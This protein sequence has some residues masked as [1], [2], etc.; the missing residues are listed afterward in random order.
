MI[1][2]Q[3]ER[4][5][6]TELVGFPRPNMCCWEPSHLY[7]TLMLLAAGPW[8]RRGSGSRATLG[9]KTQ[10][11]WRSRFSRNEI[12]HSSTAF[13]CLCSHAL[14][15]E[16]KRMWS[17]W[18]AKAFGK[19]LIC[20]G[21]GGAASR[22]GIEEF[23]NNTS[24]EWSL[25]WLHLFSKLGSELSFKSGPVCVHTALSHTNQEESMWQV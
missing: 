7:V 10:R 22:E 2:Y 6:I 11:R 19:G 18:K 24:K 21:R 4:R 1:N 9:R 15:R 3:K 25:Q 12:A 20:A 23:S 8:I 13:I 14:G 5:K 17:C 16:V